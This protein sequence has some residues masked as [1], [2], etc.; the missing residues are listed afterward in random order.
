MY[1]FCVFFR[2][3]KIRYFSQLVTVL[4]TPVFYQLPSIIDVQL[5]R[6]SCQSVA[7][8]IISCMVSLT[9]SSGS[10]ACPVGV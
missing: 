4:S 8:Q 2:D 3:I 9:L 7:S 1:S 5:H 10:T 6:V